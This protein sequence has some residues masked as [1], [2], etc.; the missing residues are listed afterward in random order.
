[1]RNII[2]PIVGVALV[3]AI[4]GGIWWWTQQ[5]TQATHGLTGSGT[6]EATQVQVGPEVSGRVVQA[7]A[8]EGQTVKAGDVL[9]RLDDSMLSV[10]RSQA[11][12]AVKTAQAQR[13]QLL[14]GAR[15]QQLE[16]A[17]GTISTTQALL[18]GAQADLD[19]L[20]AGATNDL[21]AAARSQLASA[22]ARAKL[23]HDTYAD[24]AAGRTTGQAFGVAG[25]GLGAPEEQMREQVAAANA[26]V[27]A[28]QQRLYKVLSGA[29]SDEIHSAQARVDGAQEIG[30]AHV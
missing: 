5:Q 6:I 27:V 18:A 20:V 7:M 14:V 30:R 3:A 13:D 24:V 28:A 25:K 26:Q 11:Q 19:R 29:T 21:I 15:P 22:Q 9:F 16:A 23:A 10:Q 17:Q 2:R 12:A 8:E 1:M 4:A